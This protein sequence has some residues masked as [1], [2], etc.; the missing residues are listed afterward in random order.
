MKE[1]TKE[2][3]VDLDSMN[4][5]Q[6][7]AHYFRTFDL[8]KNGKI[9]GLELLKSMQKMMSEHQHGDGDGDGEGEGG[10]RSGGESGDFDDLVDEMDD[11]LNFYDDNKDGYIS[12]G[13]FMRNHKKR[14]EDLNQE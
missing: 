8:D 11:E 4:D 12:Y 3:Y 2:E 5:A 13:E 14:I 7:M 10:S 6:L 9:D 1:H